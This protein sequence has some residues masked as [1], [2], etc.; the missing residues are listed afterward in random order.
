MNFA[1]KLGKSVLVLIGVPLRAV[2][3]FFLV[4][5][6]VAYRDLAELGDILRNIW[7]RP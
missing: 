7:R 4:G 2:L 6:V 1:A 3:T 5:T